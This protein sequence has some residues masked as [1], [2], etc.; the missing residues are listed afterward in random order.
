MATL[1]PLA[2]AEVKKVIDHWFFLLDVH[3]HVRDVLP[4]L[5]DADLEM[6]FPEATL[7]GQ[8]EFISW[9]ER[10]TRTFFDEIHVMQQYR[11]VPSKDGS[12]ADV[13]IVVKWLAKRWQPP[14]A[15]SEWLGFDSS[16]RWVVVRSQQTRKPVIH[17]YIVNALTP[18]EGSATL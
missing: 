5:A 17:T 13:D 8:E 18:L 14:A 9:Y 4:L 11:I 3:A 1:V 16:Q 6:Q 10:V 7:H 15:K 12:W 2:E